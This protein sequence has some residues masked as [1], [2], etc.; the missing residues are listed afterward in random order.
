MPSRDP[1]TPPLA[2]PPLVL[3]VEDNPLNLGFFRDV[4]E[5]EGFAV[6][7]AGDGLAALRRARERRPDVVL[8]DIQLPAVSGLEVTRWL[9]DDAALRDIPVIAVTAFAMRGDEARA[10]AAGCA[11]YLTKPIALARLVDT[12]RRFTAPPTT[13]EPI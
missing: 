2:T 7:T 13:R 6:A 3:V 5:A 10:L 11:A 1:P 9:K 8:M 4:L 12:V